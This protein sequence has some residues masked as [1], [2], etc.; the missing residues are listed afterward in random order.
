MFQNKTTSNWQNRQYWKLGIA[1]LIAIGICGWVIYGLMKPKA[2][3]AYGDF[4]IDSAVTW[5]EN[6]D[7]GN[8]DVCRKN[9]VDHDSWFDWFIK[10]RKSLGKIKVRS[11]SSRQELPGAAAE[12]KRYELKFNSRYATMSKLFPISMNREHLN[13]VTERMIIETDGKK[14]LKVLISD[15]WKSHKWKELEVD[16]DEQAQI[17]TV[18]KSVLK[19]FEERDAASFRQQ[20]AELLEMPDYFGWYQ[21]SGLKTQKRLFDLFKLLDNGK[22]SPWEFTHLGVYT[23]SGRTG[24]KDSQI[25]YH[26]SI[27]AN[28]KVRRFTLMMLMNYD[29]YQ[30]KSSGWKLTDFNFREKKTKRGK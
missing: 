12:M 28:G 11:L 29:S 25:L 30:N 6:A 14:L 17:T 18:A 15:Y 10:D 21:A 24:F 8:F 22:V 1:A 26:F 27:S 20:Y 9:I 19:K 4:A 13:N 7:C 16:A 5:L 3:P 23:P 2:T